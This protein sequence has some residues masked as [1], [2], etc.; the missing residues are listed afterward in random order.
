MF[1]KQPDRAVPALRDV[2]FTADDLDRTIAH[3][4]RINAAERGIARVI[5]E[6]VT[7]SERELGRLPAGAQG[8]HFPTD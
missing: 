7:D 8:P 2:T 6:V 3:Y 1:S 4:R 5:D